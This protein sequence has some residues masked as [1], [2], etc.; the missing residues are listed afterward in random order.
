MRS[1]L[2][3]AVAWS[4]AAGRAL[5]ATMRSPSAS[6]WSAVMLRKIGLSGR[7]CGLAVEA[8]RSTPTATVASGAAT[9]K[10]ISSTSIT[11]MKGVTL[12]SWL[13]ARSSSAWRSRRAMAL[14]RHPREGNL[15][16]LAVEVARDQAQH[17][18]RGVGDQRLVAGDGAGE[19]IVDH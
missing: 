12:I 9:M 2:F 8:G 14:L 13:S 11:S 17:L 6:E 5:R 4:S 18:G 3:F 16:L 15:A 1:S 10:M 7:G 19:V